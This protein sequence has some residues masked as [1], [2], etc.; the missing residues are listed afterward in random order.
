VAIDF[1]RE[2]L[3]ASR[4]AALHA[5]DF[6]DARPDPVLDALVA[7]ASEA[8]EAPISLVT[9]VT[10]D[11]QWFRARRG[12][13]LVS[14]PR[15]QAFC[16]YTIQSDDTMLVKDAV[17]DP[18]FM[19]NALVQGDPHIRSYAGAPIVTARGDKVG[20]LCVIDTQPREWTTAHVRVLKQLA[21]AAARAL[22]ASIAARAAVVSGEA[23]ERSVIAERR[24][25]AVFAGMA[26]GVVI[27][28][29]DSTI[30]EANLS[31][32]RVLGLTRDQLLGRTSFDPRWG[33]TRADGST[34]PAEEQPSM[35]CLA[36]GKSVSD[37]LVGLQLPDGERRW[38]HVNSQPF[39]RDGEL[40][41][42]RTATTFVDVTAQLESAA[43]LARKTRELE[44]AVAAA[45]A[46]NTAKSA[47]LANMSHE[48]KTPLN[49]VL[50][51]ATVLE[52]TGLTPSQ[53]EMVGLITSAG[54]TLQGILADILDL[55]KLE[56]DRLE[57]DAQP[58]E[59][60]AE[61]LKVTD[62]LSAQAKRNGIT[63]STSFDANSSAIVRG[64]AQRVRQI[65]WNLAA[66]AVKFTDVGSVRVRT[67]FR[68]A[69]TGGQASGLYVEVED[70][71]IGIDQDAM[72]RIFDRFSQADETI[73]RRFGGTGLGLTISRTLA[74]RMGGSISAVSTPGKGSCF[75][76]YAPLLS[77]DSS[78][79]LSTAE[80]A[81]ELAS[82]GRLRVL[83]AEDNPA[84]QRM[85]RLMLDAIGAEMILAEN[86]A[87]VCEQ[88]QAND[89]DII[90]MD[91]HMPIRDGIAAIAEIRE[92]ERTAGRPRTPVVVLTA[93]TSEKRLSE[94]RSAGADGE[95]LKPLTAQN[96]INCLNTHCKRIPIMTGLSSVDGP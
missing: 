13:E 27:Q 7:A 52:R 54:A 59:I 90:L 28:E 80:F 17:K 73:T 3:E 65:V 34:L 42:F 30:I 5:Q 23:L 92:Y 82:R 46:A 51:M 69:D 12:I 84:N 56:A 40:T 53:R 33:L 55:S 68:H 21:M 39:F 24:F 77:I 71:G 10:E 8:C 2:Q 83:V 4:L 67:S 60:R 35:R 58:F 25:Q 9:L 89:V 87:E 11:R 48:I 29:R 1:E 63:F 16:A 91:L 32:E 6:A 20:A 38:L 14:T 79:L 15:E 88:Y 95:L 85:M 75:T 70:T 37:Q 47:F 43:Q 22:E 36:T 78:I 19:H 86:G 93:D 62:I 64:D 45:E 26:E 94:A 61:I 49:A 76:F 66:N 57:L 81:G 44:Q 50:G 74:E 96:L 41:P 72:L 18:R 31:A